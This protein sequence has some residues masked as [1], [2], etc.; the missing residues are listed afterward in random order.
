MTPLI[1]ETSASVP[2]N[3][4]VL[5]AYFTVLGVAAVFV[6]LLFLGLIA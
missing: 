1:E 3:M 2:E 4:W 5:K 6:A